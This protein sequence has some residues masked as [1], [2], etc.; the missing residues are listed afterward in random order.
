LS[1]LDEELTNSLEDTDYNN[2]IEILQ[3][4]PGIGSVTSKNFIIEISSISN[5]KSVKQLCAFIG[6][7]PS[8]KQSGS[9]VFHQ[10]NISKRG[11]SYLRRTIFSLL[12]SKTK[13]DPKLA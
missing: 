9:S 5:F 1:F 2:N 7:D 4:I 10:G 3:S 11:N 13:F 8:F 12:K 6:I